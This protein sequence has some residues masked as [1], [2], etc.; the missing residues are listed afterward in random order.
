M[1][2]LVDTF[3]LMPYLLAHTNRIRVFPDVA[4]LPLRPAAALDALADALPVLRALW[5]PGSTVGVRTGPGPA[6]PINIWIG[7]QGPMSLRLTGRLADGWVA[8]IPVLPAVREV[9]AVERDD[10]RVG[11]RGRPRP[12]Y[13]APPTSGQ[14]SSPAWR[15]S[16]RPHVHLLAGTEQQR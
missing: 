10:R 16:N 8:P 15:P 6:H 3:A 13:A 4:S 5:Q 7:S 2:E 9:A 11:P 14:R 1:P 12:R